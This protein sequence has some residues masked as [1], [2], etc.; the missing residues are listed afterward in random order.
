[1]GP[2]I[3]SAGRYEFKTKETDSA[4]AGSVSEKIEMG[5]KNQGWENY[6]KEGTNPIEGEWVLPASLG[7]DSTCGRASKRVH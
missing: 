1:L 4:K 6:L 3:A 7:G 5:G 2:P